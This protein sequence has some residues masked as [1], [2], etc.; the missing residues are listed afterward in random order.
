MFGTG[1]HDGAVRIWSSPS[2]GV[3]SGAE[4]QWS[5]PKQSNIDSSLLM[6]KDSKKP[7]TGSQSP[8]VSLALLAP[9]ADI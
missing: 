6:R 1:S 8:V 3:D 7:A 4:E 5:T 2:P 9:I